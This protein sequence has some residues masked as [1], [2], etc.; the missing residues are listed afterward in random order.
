MV[1]GIMIYLMIAEDSW[2]IQLLIQ[3]SEQFLKEFTRVL[4]LITRK[5]LVKGSKYW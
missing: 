4:L 2:R 5:I 1:V 3:R